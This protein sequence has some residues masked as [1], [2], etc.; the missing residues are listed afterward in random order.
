MVAADSKTVTPGLADTWTVSPDA[1]TFTFHLH[2]GVKWSDGT[3]FTS[4]DVV[5]SA[6]WGAQNFDAFKGFQPQWSL[7]AGADAAFHT[8]TKAVTG[9]TAPD[10]ND[11]R[12]QAC[13]AE[14]GLS[15]LAG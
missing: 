3:P 12:V 5:F 14:C 1:T 4:A 7:P 6:T 9:I 13:G 2:P 15:R 8:T 11:R 10:A